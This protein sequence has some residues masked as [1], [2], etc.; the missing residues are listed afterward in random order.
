MKIFQKGKEISFE[1]GLKRTDKAYFALAFITAL[2]I[3]QENPIIPLRFD[4]LP[5]FMTTKQT[6]LGVVSTFQSSLDQLKLSPCP[7]IIFFVFDSKQSFDS[8]III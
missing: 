8:A 4:L 2:Y 1:E 3:A 7:S 6:F 5:S